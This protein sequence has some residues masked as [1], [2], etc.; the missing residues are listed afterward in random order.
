MASSGYDWLNLSLKAANESQAPP[1]SFGNQGGHNGFAQQNGSNQHNGQS[2]QVSQIQQGEFGGG[3]FGQSTGSTNQTFQGTGQSTNLGPLQSQPSLQGTGQS[4]SLAVPDYTFKN[5]SAEQL[6]NETAFPQSNHRSVFNAQDVDYHKTNSADNLNQAADQSIPL[7]LTAQELTLQESKTYM[8]WYS[9]ILARTNS[10]TI[11]M[12]DVFNFLHN[13]RITSTM[14]DKI[15]QIFLKILH[16]INIGEFFALL[17]M[18]SHC[19]LGSEPL[20]QMIKIQAPVPTP[21]SILSKKR[22][23]EEEELA[24]H[25]DVEDTT[26]DSAGK[27]LDIDSFTQ[28]M[29]TGERPGDLHKKKRLKKLKTVKFSDQ[30]VT[31]VHEVSSPPESVD[32]ASLSMDQLLQLKQQ[33]QAD[34]SR[35][36]EEEKQVLAQMGLL[37]NNFQ[38]LNAVDTALIDGTPANIHVGDSANQGTQKLQRN[39]TGPAQMAQMFS[40]SPEPP[41]L[42][43]NMTGPAQ[44]AQ[45]Y[46][47]DS[48]GYL[49]PNAQN[50]A[51]SLSPNAGTLSPNAETLSPSGMSGVGLSPNGIGRSSQ[52]GVGYD[53]YFGLGLQTANQGPSDQNLSPLRPNVTGP[54]DMARIFSP[55]EQSQEVPQISLQS[56]TSQM[57]GNTQSNTMQNR[58]VLDNSYANRSLPPPPVPTTRRTRSVSSPTPRITSP[59]SSGRV[60]PPPPPLRRRNVSNAAPPLPPKVSSPY[61]EGNGDI[62]SSSNSS[63]ANI[64]DDLKALQDEVDRIRD[65]T[66]GFW[67][68]DTIMR[69]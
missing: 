28:F 61:P 12:Q 18:I 40:P 10:R 25:N 60:P 31:D 68:R 42:K 6:H 27:P 69:C 55:P 56:F 11:T 51:T 37:V 29:L 45:M 17:R 30:I 8:R 3:S 15:R 67:V 53:D 24:T 52:N 20:R 19:L 38:H 64:L 41:L 33:S 36:D 2:A 9:D 21:P 4:Q 59:N 23:N 63:T 16:S 54:A 58:N 62:Y 13:F 65:M 39:M 50:N 48:Q 49:S 46:R 32:Y 44:M 57:T 14:K 22:H 1:V 35:A 66:G 7:S 5:A 26:D 47:A 43:P 34:Q